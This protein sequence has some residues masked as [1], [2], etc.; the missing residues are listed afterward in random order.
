M[1]KCHEAIMFNWQLVQPI[2]YNLSISYWSTL[3]HMFPTLA[4]SWA[5]GLLRRVF[6]QTAIKK[7]GCVRMTRHLL[8]LTGALTLMWILTRTPNGQ[9]HKSTDK[10]NKYGISLCWVSNCEWGSK[11]CFVFFCNSGRMSN[12]ETFFSVVVKRE[13]NCNVFFC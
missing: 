12:N 7:I 3:L 4:F 10:L 1:R 5:L 9:H 11:K 8:I 13:K 2:S 6:D